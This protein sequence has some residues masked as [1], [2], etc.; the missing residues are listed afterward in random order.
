MIGQPRFDHHA[1]A[2]AKG[3][4]DSARFCVE[5]LLFALF[6][7]GDVR[8]EQII[9]LK[10]FDHSL[11]SAN[12]AVTF[13]PVQA[14][15][16]IRHK[17]VCHLAHI[18]LS[19]EHVEHIA[20]GNL[21]AFANVEIVEIMARCDF[22]SAA[23]KLW[24]GMFIGHNRHFA[25]RNRQDDMLADNAFIAL[26][27]GMDGNRHIGEHGFG[28]GCRNLDVI[29][30]ISQSNAICQRIFE[31]PETALFVARFNLKVAN[32]RFQLGV[33]ID[34]PFVAIDE[35]IIVQIDKGLGHRLRKM[36][37]HGKLLAAPIHRAA[38]T[39]QLRGDRAAACLFPFP[40]LV[41][42]VIA[43]IFAAAI[44]RRLHLALD[45]HLGRNAGMVCAHD[46][47]SVFAA[48]SLV[49]HN[50]VLQ[51]V[52]ERMADMQAA[53]D[54]GRRVDDGKA[55]RIGA[56]GPEQAA[57]LPMGIPARLN[58]CGVESGGQL[59]I[60]HGFRSVSKP[61]TRG[62]NFGSNGSHASAPRRA[63]HMHCGRLQT[64]D[65]RDLSA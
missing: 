3:R 31:A 36:R 39:A 53:C 17:P 27:I 50:D 37:V 19:I 25:A 45:H 35:V 5:N 33:P 2:I 9:S 8:D 57:L 28:A 44:T 49:T 4:C 21:C 61:Q 15:E 47:Q 59:S 32:C 54:I 62:G 14:E 12:N 18:G 46:P 7:L 55:G 30:A 42:E 6:G 41:D 65:V 22:H 13:E 23:A 24:I 34:Q 26:I 40:D 64:C 63:Q 58:R 10:A 60:G 51:R 29:T 16:F 48:Q 11:A 38:Q 1:A 52:V 20:R 56:L 43:L